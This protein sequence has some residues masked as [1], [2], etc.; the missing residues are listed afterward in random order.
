MPEL[1]VTEI[2]S[3]PDLADTFSV[4]RRTETVGSNG[5]PTLTEVTT[6]NVVGVVTPGDPGNLTRTDDSA[7][8]SNLITISTTFRLRALGAGFQA[9]VILYDGMRYT[10]K[11]MKRWQRFGAGWVKVVAE[12]E[13]AADPAPV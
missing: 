12:S 5:R 1:D 6:D 8:A 4:V 11:A 13:N 3:D 10:V 7:M 2:L 9:D